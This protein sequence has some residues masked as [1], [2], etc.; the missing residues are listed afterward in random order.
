MQLNY[1][2]L[3]ALDLIIKESRRVTI[4]LADRQQIG[5]DEKNGMIVSSAT[6]GCLRYVMP[7]GHCGRIYPEQLVAL[8]IE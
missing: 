4:T 1:A 8:C 5:S 3:V 6:E 7:N 2:D